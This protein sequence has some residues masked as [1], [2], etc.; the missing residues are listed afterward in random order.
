MTLPGTRQVV[1]TEWA[2]EHQPTA[3]G[4]MPVGTQLTDTLSRSLNVERMRDDNRPTCMLV[5]MDL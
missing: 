4:P 3:R 5:L 1:G 2:C